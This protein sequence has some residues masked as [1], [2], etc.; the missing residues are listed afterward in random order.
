MKLHGVHIDKALWEKCK[1]KTMK[2]E[3]IFLIRN[4]EQRRVV[5]EYVGVENLLKRKR[6]KDKK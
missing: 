4:I 3:E 2:A 6:A 1:S 5:T